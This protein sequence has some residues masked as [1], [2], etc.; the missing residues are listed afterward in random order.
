MP[1]GEWRED[2]AWPEGISVLL[3]IHRPRRMAEITFAWKTGRKNTPIDFQSLF[4][5][6]LGPRNTPMHDKPTDFISLIHSGAFSVLHEALFPERPQEQP[7]LG[8]P[9]G[10]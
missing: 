6:R 8:R 4:F 9:R 7:P 1:L 3:K 5:R 2:I 10:K